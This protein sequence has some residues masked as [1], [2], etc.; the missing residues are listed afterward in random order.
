MADQIIQQGQ[1]AA[2]ST[3][4]AVQSHKP[5]LMEMMASQYGMEPGKFK[6]VL[7][8]TIFPQDKVATMEQLG[9]FCIVA[10]KYELNPLTKE[11]Y[12]FPAKGGGIVPVVGI[13]GWISLVQRQKNYNGHKFVYVWENDKVGGKLLAATCFIFRKDLSEPIEHTEFSEECNRDTEPWKK[14]PRRML[15]HKAFIQC[16]RYA[17]GLGGVYDQDE[18]ERIIE[19]EL[20]PMEGGG[21]R[22]EIQMPKRT[23][24]ITAGTTQAI[25]MPNITYSGVTGNTVTLT[26]T[27]PVTFGGTSTLPTDVQIIDAE[28]EDDSQPKDYGFGATPAAAE[29]ATQA[30]DVPTGEDLFDAKP[31]EI[32]PA[33]ATGKATIGAGRAKRIRAIAFSKK[34]RTEED[35]KELMAAFKIMDLADYPM[36]RHKELENWAEGK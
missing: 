25:I 16:A 19:A 36:S 23:E 29:E 20:K 22:S 15:T 24:Q 11:I 35:Y 5:G 13:D 34:T 21:F 9:M 26:V 28:P 32:K 12:A 2:A 18:A 17:F 30:V 31:E 27:E 7:L 8:K 6:D 3:A 4:I 10:H 1:P 14:W 33:A